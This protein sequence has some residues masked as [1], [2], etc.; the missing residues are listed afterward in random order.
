MHSINSTHHKTTFTDAFGIICLKLGTILYP[1]CNKIEIETYNFISCLKDGWRG[2]LDDGSG[3]GGGGGGANRSTSSKSYNGSFSFMKGSSFKK[4][5]NPW[6]LLLVFG[7]GV[8]ATNFWFMYSPMIMEH[9]DCLYN[10][11][12]FYQAE[13]SILSYVNDAHRTG[14]IPKVLHFM[15]YDSPGD[16]PL[17]DSW[18][19][20]CKKANLGWGVRVWSPEQNRKLV[21]L[22]YPWLLPTYDTLHDNITKN[23][24]SILLYMHHYGGAYISP[25]TECL[26]GF[27]EGY[28]QPTSQVILIKKN[29][30]YPNKVLLSRKGHPLWLWHVNEIQY[31]LDQDPNSN[32]EDKTGWRLFKFTVKVFDQFGVAGPTRVDGLDVRNGDN[33]YPLDWNKI[34]DFPTC[35]NNSPN[36]NSDDCKKSVID[37]VGS[38]IPPFT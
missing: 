10:D 5:S 20:S 37:S 31:N 32:I 11:F 9:V 30:M 29:D 18:M 1:F 3:G 8:F 17:F 12:T 22:K 14:V 4:S 25:D 27:D 33:I 35:D 23:D 15:K 36:Y 34:N 19:E 24:L 6:N 16:Q 28:I 38:S 21:E 7:L 2:L 26:R 13:S